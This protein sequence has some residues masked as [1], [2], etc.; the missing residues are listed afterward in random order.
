MEKSKTRRSR[1]RLSELPDSLIFHIFWFLPMRDVVR[2]TILSKRWENLWIT[3]T[4]LKFDGSELYFENDKVRNFVNRALL[5]WRG[6]KILKLKIDFCSHP[7][8]SFFSDFDLWVRFAVDKNVEELYVHRVK[9]SPDQY[10]VPQYLYSCSSVKLLSFKGC[11]LQIRGNVRWNHLKSL[12]IDDKC[13]INCEDVF[14]QILRGSPQLEVLT[15]A[16]CNNTQNLSIQSS[17]L[18]KLSIDNHLYNCHP[19]KDAKLR[20]WTPNLETLEIWGVPYSEC[21]LT[22]VSSLTHATLGF[23]GLDIYEDELF[24]DH[25]ALWELLRQIV[26]TIQHV[27]SVTLSDWCIKVLGDPKKKNLLSPLSNVKFLK[28][29]AYFEGYEDIVNLLEIFPKVK[30]LVLQEEREVQFVNL[31]T[32]TKFNAKSCLKFQVHLPDSFLLHLRE[33]EISWADNDDSIFPFIEIVLKHA[34]NLER[35]V[36]RVIRVEG[37]MPP[38]DSLFLASRKLLRM[39]R[40]SPNCRVDIL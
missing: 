23:Y 20:I 5:Y 18:K 22:S 8:G 40:S 4:C 1:D 15:L 19:F 34:C 13:Y 21:L 12:T 9:T 36:I 7:D 6:I 14:N 10:L 2:T 33:V 17:S 30:M 38:S 29:H 39:Q 31:L 26:P 25:N 37:L 11:N 24:H 35:I 27:E 28:L 3:T 32:S 16:L